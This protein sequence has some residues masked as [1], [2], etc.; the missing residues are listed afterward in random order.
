[1]GIRNLLTTGKWNEAQPQK[2][3]QQKPAQ[4]NSK[5]IDPNAFISGQTWSVGYTGEKNFGEVGPVK[6]YILHYNILR[7]RSWQLYLDSD[8]AQTVIKRYCLWIVK[9]GLRLQLSP[10]V[11]VLERYGV[12]GQK[13]DKFTREVEELFKVWASSVNSTHSSEMSFMKLSAEALKNAK[14]GGDVLIIMRLKNGNVTVQAVDG[15]HLV[16]DM[17]YIPESGNTVS[18]GIEM[19]SSGKHVRYFVKTKS[20]KVE[21]IDAFDKETGIR[22]AFLVYGSRYRLDNYRGIPII[23]GAMETITKVDRYKEASVSQ[24]EN[25]RNVAYTVEH[26]DASTGENP[27][28]DIVG[29]MY[30]D[31]NQGNDIKSFESG[32]KIAK[33]VAA[34]TNSMA[35]NLPQGA[36]LA[37]L[38]SKNEMFFKD[39]YGTNAN[40]I[41]AMVGIPPNVAFSLYNDSFSASRAATK[42]WENTMDYERTDFSEQML[43]KVF[44]YWF[45]I[46]VWKGKIYAPGFVSAVENG[47]F[48][49]FE[50]YT[51]SRFVGPKFPHIDPVKEATAARLRL[52]KSGEHIPLGNAQD[53][54]EDLMSGDFDTNVERFAQELKKVKDLGIESEQGSTQSTE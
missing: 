2:T 41:C 31:V 30:G 34:K 26:S 7:N 36:K 24:A 20:G 32:E 11:S 38:E 10:M 52:G 43:S 25:A 49:I 28:D 44:F 29:E 27:L 40:A 16:T 14:V 3:V 13:S 37:M 12:R 9:N 46:Q 22:V 42:D 19:D 45:Y 8:I 15:E 18:D 21:K 48:M 5:E 17:F 6:K 35:L 23:A 33:T 54:S 4:D 47:E 1:M 53:I 51:Q 50:A 39:F